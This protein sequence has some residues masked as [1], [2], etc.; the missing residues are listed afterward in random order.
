MGDLDKDAVIA[1]L[2]A[3]LAMERRN[4]KAEGGNGEILHRFPAYVVNQ[5]V[6]MPQVL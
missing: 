1:K 4:K 6:K 3:Q 5:F 2:K